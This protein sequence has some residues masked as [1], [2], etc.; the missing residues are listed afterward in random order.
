MAALARRASTKERLPLVDVEVGGE[1]GGGP[2]IALADDLVEVDRLVVPRGDTES[3][4]GNMDDRFPTREF[5]FSC[6]APAAN[7]KPVLLRPNPPIRP[8]GSSFKPE[9]PN[10]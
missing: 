6:P 5:G 2:R 1:D 8:F 3:L 9:R 4:H 10:E 7:A